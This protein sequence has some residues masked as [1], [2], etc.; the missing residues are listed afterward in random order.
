M[1]QNGTKWHKCHRHFFSPRLTCYILKKHQILLLSQPL[2]YPLPL[3]SITTHLALLSARIPKLLSEGE[4]DPL[5]DDD[6]EA[7]SYLYPKTS[8]NSNSRLYHPT[9]TLLVITVGSNIIFDPAK[10][11]L[12]VAEA[13][14]AV[15]IGFSSSDSTKALQILAIRT[16]DPPSRIT[17]PGL[18]NSLNSATGAAVVTVDEIITARELSTDQGVWNPPRG[19]LSRGLIGRITKAV[20]GP[21]NGVAKEVM[22]GL[23]N[24]V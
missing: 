17:P 3:L 13:V 20:L 21:P 24:V 11:E 16:I 9:I 4:E 10:E 15:S 6:W 2:S 19:G 8:S 18:A 5:F 22:D 7:S 12:A 1:A 23:A 14:I